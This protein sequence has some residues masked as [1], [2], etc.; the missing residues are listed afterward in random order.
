MLKKIIQQV[1]S[2][3]DARSVLSVREHD[4]KARTPVMDFFNIPTMNDQ[5]VEDRPSEEYLANLT[6]SSSR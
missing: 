4:Q 1:H 6:E 2:H 3:L 5:C